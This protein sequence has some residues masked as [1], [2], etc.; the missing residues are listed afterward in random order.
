MYIFCK[1]FLNKQINI[2]IYFIH[3]SCIFMF[4]F[5]K[6]NYVQKVSMILKI[7][8]GITIFVIPNY[9]ILF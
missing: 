6:N 1:F 9:T 5:K 7:V 2:I 8:S 4:H 3:I